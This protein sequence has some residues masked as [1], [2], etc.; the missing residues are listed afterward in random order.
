VIEG[1]DP[2]CRGVVLLGLEAPEDELARA[3]AAARR[4]RTVRG[5]AVGR[6]IFADAAREWLADNMTDQ[7]A[8]ADMTRRFEALTEIWQGLGETAAA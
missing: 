3:F 2:Y 4:A 1:R 6:T 8:I 7:Q 5:F